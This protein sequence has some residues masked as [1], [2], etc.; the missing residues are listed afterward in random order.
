MEII[1]IIAAN[2]VFLAL[3]GFAARTD[4][5]VGRVEERTRS[6]LSRLTERLYSVNRS[7]Q[8]LQSSVEAGR[9]ADERNEREAAAERQ[10]AEAVEEI[11]N[12]CA[13]RAQETEE[14]K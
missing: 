12:Y 1:A 13:P 10:F 6:D 8:A 14:G 2:I 11:M 3:V 7:L 4:R 5:R 9:R